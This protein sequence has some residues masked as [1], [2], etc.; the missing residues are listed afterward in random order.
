[1]SA[2]RQP[3]LPKEKRRW[4]LGLGWRRVAGDQRQAID[5]AVEAVPT[6]RTPDA[7]GADRDAAA[8]LL[9]PGSPRSAGTEARV[10]EADG[11]D[12]F[13]G[14]LT[15]LVWHPR[16]PPLAPPEHLEA[17]AEDRP[18]PAV[19][20]R[21]VD[22]KMRHAARTLPSSLAR[23][24]SRRRNPNRTSSLTTAPALLLIV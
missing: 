2:P 15:E 19:V 17:A 4:V 1:M 18:S 5:P 21:R 8:A 22:P 10:T 11:D 13:L 12:P 14:D 24:N 9:G 7:I 16:W 23:L 3:R 6:K 20:G